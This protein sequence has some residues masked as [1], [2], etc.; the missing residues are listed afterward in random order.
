MVVEGATSSSAEDDSDD[1][2]L[3]SSDELF[4]PSP[5]NE[6]VSSTSH[7]D[8]KVNFRKHQVQGCWKDLS[9]EGMLM[10]VT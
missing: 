7:V 6:G 2:E 3:S 4:S 5:V 10:E 8:G 1:D 9:S